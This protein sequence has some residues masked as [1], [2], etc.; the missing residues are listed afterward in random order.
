MG[1]EA[2]AVT[3]RRKNDKPASTRLRF[4]ELLRHHRGKR[5]QRELAE[6][7]DVVS[8]Y[9]ALLE[10]GRRSPSRDLALK[11]AEELS[12]RGDERA[13]FLAAALGLSVDEVA[14][15]VGEHPA[16]LALR[17]F[18]DAKEG[19]PSVTESLREL[20]RELLTAAMNRGADRSQRSA[21]KSAELL[22]MGYF[23][24]ME[25]GEDQRQ[26]TTHTRRQQQLE[27]GLIE[28]IATVTDT[29]VPITRRVKLVKELNQVASQG[30]GQAEGGSASPSEKRSR[31]KRARS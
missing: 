13:R 10:A 6:A 31:G 24:V 9:I 25:G 18:L 26:D 2:Q 20:V 14:A 8:N 22:G 29:S 19:D 30:L 27:E 16:V 21:L 23:H 5:T 4:G 15:P 28:L 17:R 3:K 7:A 11:L 1:P 12:L